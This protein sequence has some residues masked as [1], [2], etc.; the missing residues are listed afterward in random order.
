MGN[1]RTVRRKLA[2]EALEARTLLSGGS[3][4]HR[5]VW[6]PV[7]GRTD[8]ARGALVAPAPKDLESAAA[9]DGAKSA[10]DSDKTSSNSRAVPT[11]VES[12]SDGDRTEG[13]SGAKNG[14]S[15]WS[16]DPTPSGESSA[17]HSHAKLNAPNGNAG[18]TGGSSSDQGGHSSDGGTA[19]GPGTDAGAIAGGSSTKLEPVETGAAAVSK[20]AAPDPPSRPSAKPSP[21]RQLPD[22]P[23]EENGGT[24]VGD[25]PPPRSPAPPV[26]GVQGSTGLAAA[27]AQIQASRSVGPVQP[28]TAAAT[29]AADAVRAQ[30]AADLS[31]LEASDKGPAGRFLA[32]DESGPSDRGLPALGEG[33]PTVAEPIKI[34]LLPDSLAPQQSDLL[35][36]VLALDVAGLEQGVL[37]F[38]ARLD[39]LGNTILAAQHEAGITPWLVALAMTG[40]TLEFTRRRRKLRAWP[41]LALASDELTWT[42]G[43]ADRLPAT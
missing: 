29:P 7:W 1:Q 42:W 37:Q 15:S 13:F 2:V 3:F 27:V 23:P 11:D 31:G 40:A 35:G 30:P 19:T 8:T 38:F 17:T 6:E 10:G 36:A 5:A 26:P 22:A 12:H 21:S 28:V 34:P 9:A 18:G 41:D 4:A 33:S 24:P 16:A 39:G 32:N 20:P 14:G 43:L 25:A